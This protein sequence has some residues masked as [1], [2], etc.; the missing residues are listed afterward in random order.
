MNRFKY[1]LGFSLAAALASGA[2]NAQDVADT[3]Q[4]AVEPGE[5]L[6]TAQ[7]RAERL[8]DVPISMTVQS[9][10]QLA[11]IGVVDSRGL[12]QVTP[13]LTMQ[14]QSGFLNPS[15]RGISTTV[16]SAGAENPIAIY[17]DG[18][19]V[20]SFAGSIINLPDVDR[21]E[22]LKGPQGTLFG[23]NATGGAIQV[24]TKAPTFDPTGKISVITGI[25][26]GAG[27][28]R[29]AYDLGVEG[30]VSGPIIADRLAASIAF[31]SR[32]TNGYARNIAYGAVSDAADRAYGSDRLNKK[33]EET[34][35]GKLL[36][37]PSDDL[38]ILLT[39]YYN[40]RDTDQG[41][42]GYVLRNGALTGAAA[43]DSQGA[44]LY[45]ERIT[46][47][48]PWEYAFD[49]KRPSGTLR[50]YGFS[51]K[52]DFDISA[53][54]FTSTTAYSNTYSTEQVDSDASYAPSCLAVMACVSPYDSLSDRNFSQEL[55]FT[56]RDFGRFNF[57]AGGN[58]LT[59]KSTV[60][61]VVSDFEFGALPVGGVS[62]PELFHYDQTVKTKAFGLF[63]EGNFEI[64]DLLTLTA[65]IRYSNEKK[66]GVLA[67]L[68]AGGVDFFTN[69]ALLANKATAW[70]PRVSL[71]YEVADR[72]NIYATFSRGF[73]SGLIPGGDTR[74][75]ASLYA[76][77]ATGAP[78]TVNPEKI[79]AFEIGFK[80]AQPGYS[81]NAAAFFY[82]YKD[83][84]VQASLGQGGTVLAI[85]NA[86]SARIWGIDVDGT[87]R[88]SD[89]I[90][91]RGGVSWIPHAKYR[92][93]DG[94]QVALPVPTDGFNNG[95]LVDLGG[96]R[97]FK[98]PKL[99][100][101]A[102]ANFETEVGG[103]T[104]NFSPNLYYASRLYVD[105]TYI[106]STTNFKLGAEIGY[107]PEGSN[108]R[109]SLWGKN[110]TNNHAFV[111]Y[112]V[113]S[114]ATVLIPGDPREF[115]MTATF[116]F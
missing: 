66:T 63:A 99:T 60:K 59:G 32:R 39:G 7:R 8:Q 100:L 92:E 82:N 74:Y 36:F 103:G 98:T 111:S 68:G 101:T 46:G 3:A 9:G 95:D 94:A 19:Y 11:R 91:L 44:A 90:S 42:I 58:Y 45:P 85:Q 21:V 33:R 97:L 80:T 113:T 49:A 57:V 26:D 43:T 69:E 106:V 115:G 73:K 114:N 64:T 12:E 89:G 35:R 34:I 108:F 14:Q 38:R 22:V 37:T 13:G 18:V 116:E 52:I 47:T 48:R 41:E 70:T 93:F 29:S 16:V 1:I 81:L 15:L 83:L 87:V 24:F 112:Q 53:G 86:A 62:Y 17:L 110:L 79:D 28:S 56:S 61:V 88:V 77:G 105:P 40:H 72:S 31:S 65:G 109:F 20:S 2:A 6:V 71:R 51:S 30:Y 25:F 10:E 5:I 54:T 96:S 55:I 75:I 27:S 104:L 76:G 4:G 50:G 102:G 23:R 67:N 84:Q 78:P 107:R